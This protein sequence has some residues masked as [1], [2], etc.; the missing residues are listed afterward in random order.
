MLQTARRNLINKIGLYQAKARIN[1]TQGDFYAYVEDL[2]AL[3]KLVKKGSLKLPA[4]I[5]CDNCNGQGQFEDEASVVPCL[6]CRT[7]DG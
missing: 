3:S 5:E 1:R 7:M 4:P 6:S 2:K